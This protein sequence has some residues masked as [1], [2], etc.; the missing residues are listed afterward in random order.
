ML[1]TFAGMSISSKNNN[2]DIDWFKE[3]FNSPYYHLLYQDRN[4]AEAE[5]FINQL[6]QYLTPKKGVKILD[7]ACGKGRHALQINKLGYHVDAFDL[8]EN[9]IKTAQEFENKTLQFYINDIRIPLKLNYYDYCFNLF[10]SFGYFSKE[11]DNYKAIQAIADSMN[12]NGV[13]IIDFMNVHKVINE[14]VASEQK[15]IAG[16]VFNITRSIE[17]GFIIKTIQL[18]DKGRF[19]QYQEKVKVISLANFKNYFKAAGLKLTTI[20]GDYKLSDFDIASSDRL[21]MI[22][23]K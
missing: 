5:K 2:E 16:V 21:I 17:E 7:I 14:L 6:F 12:P 3:W 10:T 9:S 23:N 19:Y 1:F 8:S 20:F 15:I 22:T 18:E 4:A 11:E 13:F